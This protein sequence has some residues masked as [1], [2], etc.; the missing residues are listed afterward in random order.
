MPNEPTRTHY[1]FKGWNT[2]ADGSGVT[3]DSTTK[4]DQATLKDALKEI[5]GT[6]TA[7]ETTLYAQWDIDPSVPTSDKVNVTFNKNLDLNGND[8]SPRVITLYKGDSIGYDITE[9]TNGTFEFDGW[10]TAFDGTGT[11]FDKD[12]KIN[13]DTTYYATWFKYLKIELVNANAEYTGQVISPKYN[14]YQIKY[15]DASKTTY[16]KVADSDIAKNETLPAGFTA[17]V[18]D[19]DNATTTIQNVGVYTIAI[20]IDNAGTYANGYKIGV[21]DSTFEVTSAKLT[22][23]VDPDTQKQKAGSSR[24]DPVITVVDATGNTVGKS[25]YDIKYYTWTDAG[26]TP[27]GNIQKSELSEVTDITKV[28]K[29]VVAVELKANSNY[30]IDSVKSTTTEAVLLYDG[31]T[32]GYAE[33][34]D[35]KV[36]GNIVYEVLANDPSIKEIKANSVKGSTVDSTALP[37]KDSQYKND[38]AFDNAETPAIKDYYVRVPDVDAD[39]IQFNVTLTNPDTTTITASDGTTL[40]PTKN[41]DGTYTIKAPLTNKGQTE[42]TITITTKAGTDNDAPTLTYTFHVQ[43]LVAPKITLNYGNSPVG[44]IMKADNISVSNKL[45]AVADFEKNNKYSTNADYLPAGKTAGMLYSPLAWGGSVDPTVNLDRDATAL[46]SFE[47]DDFIDPGFVAVDSLGNSVDPTDVR[48]SITVTVL[49]G[50]SIIVPDKDKKT[51]TFSD[52]K[53][54]PIANDLF[55]YANITGDA[56]KVIQPDV[57][58]L[59]YSFYDN[60]LAKTITN[61]RKVVILPLMGDTTLDGQISVGDLVPIKNYTANNFTFVDSTV[62]TSTYNLGIYR[63][64]DTTSDTQISVGDLVPIKNH[65]ANVQINTYYSTFTK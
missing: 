51:N 64:M 41:G 22:V 53:E 62:K 43:Q 34:T 11:K 18:T 59:T 5:A 56:T 65:T 3:V 61:T 19:K 52:T 40:T 21:Q 49:P 29:Y 38:V 10:K 9:P 47:Y 45:V 63:V 24:K 1:V 46:F 36:G 57:Y 35:A 44:E 58:E 15:D 48:R 31:K 37:F 14:I 28:G 8:T 27:D 7:Y 17:T 60:A 33:Y 30:V 2:K 16:T 32:T 25:E 4:I 50:Q 54:N 13:T 20:S 23:N 12:T 39:S 26:A 42:N 55:T 6:N